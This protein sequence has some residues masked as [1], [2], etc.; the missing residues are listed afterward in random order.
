[1]LRLGLD[2]KNG[3]PVQ[4]SLDERRQGTYIIGT[5]G[6]GK[7]T[8]LKN[9][10]FQDLWGDR[11]HG[12]CVL[13]PH[14]D[15]IDDL[16]GLVPQDRV[17]D[18]ILFDPMDTER[19]FGLNLLE[20]DRTNPH[21]VRWVVSTVM[22]TLQRLF[23]YSWGPRLEHVLRHTLL[24]AMALPDSTF[25]ELLLLLTNEA[26]RN[27]VV[28]KLQD[29]ILTQFWA[30]LPRSQKDRYELISS[31][32]NKISPFITD[33][34][35][36][37]I[38]GQP[39]NTVNLTK[40]MDEGKI[41]FV[42]LSKG[43]LG[44]ANSSLLGAVLV[45]LMLITS[46]QRRSIP[47]KQR[48]PFHLIVD[49][50]QNF[51]TE[52]FA[53]LQS[54]A[55]KYAVDVVVAHQFRDQLDQLSL[56]STLN[57]GN[58]VVFRVTGRDSYSL[59]SQF[60]NTPPSPDTRVEP[61]Y[62]EYEF[63]GVDALIETK[64]NTGEGKL[65]QEV[66]LPRRPYSDVE[67]EMANRLSILPN[68]EAWCRLIRMSVKPGE[69]PKLSEHHIFTEVLGEKEIS[70]NIAAQVRKRSRQMAKPREEVEKDIT[71]RSQGTIHEPDVADAEEIVEAEEDV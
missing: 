71:Q 68:Y 17:K 70:P 26:F 39:Y 36:R 18:V 2:V 66:E 24:T 47:Q 5:T 61:I 13:D 44:E 55:R 67:A 3:A 45:N 40:V 35:M 57:V 16:L 27:Q 58:L 33:R 51:A 37:N 7:S 56:G 9:I 65:Y 64:L 49:E 41:L 60:D 43:D 31:T 6:T 38:I 15:L 29:P 52:S 59:A 50:F 54:E 30:D 23:A 14:G 4:L 62:Q 12:L 20:C 69:R 48:K 42:N 53:I 28:A 22:G 63:R 34:S 8:L 11:E 19:P 32:L 21:Q 46:L 1:M 25:I 10:I